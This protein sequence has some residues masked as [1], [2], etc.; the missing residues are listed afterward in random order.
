[1]VNINRITA[2]RIRETFEGRIKPKSFRMLMH[3][4][5]IKSRSSETEEMFM[6]RVKP[7]VEKFVIRNGDDDESFWRG[8]MI[9]RGLMSKM[10]E[11]YVSDDDSDSDSDVD[12]SSASIFSIDMDNDTEEE[13]RQ[14]WIEI[15]KDKF[16]I[17][18]CEYKIL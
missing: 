9:R 6:I 12:E 8:I 15:E 3:E 2:G 18:D 10:N 11:E 14:N 4:N 5:G 7:I 1:M 16:D 13:D 17:K